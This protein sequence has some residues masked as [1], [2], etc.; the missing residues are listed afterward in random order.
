MRF[1][2]VGTSP[3]NKYESNIIK[4]T[5]KNQNKILIVSHSLAITTSDKNQAV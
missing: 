4:T 5:Q 1:F 2:L 3:K